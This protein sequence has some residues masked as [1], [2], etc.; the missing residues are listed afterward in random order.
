VTNKP[1]LDVFHESGLTVQ[2]RLE[3]SCYHLELRFPPGEAS[4]QARP[5][6]A[7]HA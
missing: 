6:G 2:A 5:T 4:R 1:M 3:G 7:V